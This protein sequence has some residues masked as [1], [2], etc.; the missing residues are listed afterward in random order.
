MKK[1]ISS[2]PIALCILASIFLFE[3]MEMF[4]TAYAFSYS[5]YF[6]VPIALVTLALL[7]YMINKRYFLRIPP[8]SY[9]LVF[10]LY[11]YMLSLF[12]GGYSTNAQYLTFLAPLFV[13]L[14][15]TT[16]QMSEVSKGAYLKHLL[17]LFASL[18]IYYF[19]NFK[20]NYVLDFEYQ[21]NAA[22]TLLYFLPL[23]LCIKKNI[24]K[25]LGVLAI[26]VAMMFS[27]K[28]GGLLSYAIA[29]ATYY[30]FYGFSVSDKKNQKRII[31]GTIL[32]LIFISYL[33]NYINTFSGDAITDRFLKIEE[34][35][36]SGRV[37]IW[38]WIFN[39]YEYNAFSFDTLLGHGWNAVLKNSGL[40]SA[41]NDFLE[42]L[43][44]FGIIA[45]L[46]YIIFWIKLGRYAIR[47]FKK[48]SEYA[49]PLA[50]LIV[51]I[52]SNSMVSHVI[53][54]PKYLVLVMLVLGY[55]HT[56]SY[57]TL[58]TKNK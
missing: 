24:I 22:Y 46:L 35:Q 6:L 31:V 33:F 7:Y 17:M 42:I 19:L 26:L 2:L 38:N 53:T 49:A 18:M 27:L 45:L 20:K 12:F 40:R 37:E 11:T 56:V 34:D 5:L 47:L 1:T 36:G 23:V 54:Y 10:L 4:P 16:A 43:Y 41:H 25:I 21:D 51:L 29:T 48:N 13:Y 30:I 44:D 57:K 39:T 15:A 14:F 3:M 55:I 8:M 28:R 58:N 9:L 52:L 32:S 50:A